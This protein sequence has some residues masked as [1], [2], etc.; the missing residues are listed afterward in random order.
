M[1]N[2]DL[3]LNYEDNFFYYN[4]N[5]EIIITKIMEK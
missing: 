1:K 4:Y 2:I 5:Y 3:L